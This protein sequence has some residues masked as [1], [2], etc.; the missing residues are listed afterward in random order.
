MNERPITSYAPEHSDRFFRHLFMGARAYA[1]VLFDHRGRI[2]GWSQGAEQLFG[3]RTEEVLGKSGALIF[4]EEDREAGAPKKEIDRAVSEGYADDTRWHVTKSGER[5]WASAAT[6]AVYD[7]GGAVEGFAKIVRD[8]TDLKRYEEALE[9]SNRDLDAFAGHVAHE[10]HS[11]LAG[12]RLA[13]NRLQ[14]RYAGALEN[15][16]LELVRE[17]HTAVSDIDRLTAD[18]LAFARLH[19]SEELNRER[20]DCGE[21]VEEAL[22]LLEDEIEAR[23]AEVTGGELPTVYANRALLVRVFRNLIGNGITYNESEVPHVQVS[24]IEEADAWVFRVEDNGT[25]I[26]EEDRERVFDLLERGKVG[27]AAGLGVGLALAR[28]VVER[29]GGRIWVESEPGHGSTFYFTLPK[30]GAQRP[31]DRQQ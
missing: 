8:R 21:A 28:R 24:A 25:G 6:E 30:E 26:P 10:V 23:N 2:N 22:V 4:T 11:P 29:R 12:V 13:L 9:E 5:F 17:A 3:W 31:E 18:L 16:D 1:I 7:E 19:P 14:R 27:E 15:E 20:T